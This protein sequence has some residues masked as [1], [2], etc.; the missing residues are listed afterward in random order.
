M[1]AFCESF[2]L[3]A[4]SLFC[5][6]IQTFLRQIR[7]WCQMNLPTKLDKPNYGA[8]LET[9]PTVTLRAAIG[10]FDCFGAA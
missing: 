8:R 3:V 6:R 9:L 10:T 2:P 1:S 7:A 5:C 4:R